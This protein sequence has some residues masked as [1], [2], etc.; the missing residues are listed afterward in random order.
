MWRVQVFSA[1][2]F[3]ALGVTGVL[4]AQTEEFP[5]TPFLRVETGM[6]TAM[7]NRL[8]VDINERFLVT[9]SD[10]K[11]AR[12]WDLRNGNLLKILRPPQGGGNIGRLYAAAMSP[13]GVTVAVGGYTRAS[14]SSIYL[15]DRASG[16]LARHIDGLPSSVN[17]LSYSPDGRFLAAALGSNGMRVY[18]TSD[19]HEI[20]S[21]IQYNDSSYSVDFDRTGRLVATSF[22][23]SL[24]LYNSM[25]RL[26]HK[27][28]APGGKQPF[29]A[30]FSPDGNYIAVGFNDSTAVNVLSGENLSFLYAP[31]TSKVT[32]SVST[33]A[34]SRDGRLLYAA[35]GYGFPLTVVVRWT[36]GGRGQVSEWPTSPSSVMDLIS[37]S[38]GQIAFASADPAL[39]VLD[40]RGRTL[41]QRTQESFDLTRIPDHHLRLSRQGDHVVFGFWLRSATSTNQRN[42]RFS[43]S[44]RTFQLNPAEDAS[45]HSPRTDGLS[46]A[47]WKDTKRP[48]LDGRALPL[49]PYDM[50]RALAISTKADSFLLGS[51]FTLRLFDRQGQQRWRTDIPGVAWDVNLTPDGRYAVA[52]LGDGTLRW[53][54]TATGKEVLAFFVH[55]DGER[56][57][58]WTPEGFFDASPGGEALVGYHLNQGMDRAGE[59]VNVDQVFNL[60]YRPDLVGQRLQPGAAETILAA[61]EKIGDIR[62]VLAGGLPPDLERLSPAESQ[63][64]GEFDLKFR[65]KN[66]GGGIGRVVYR[67]DGVEQAGREVGIPLPGSDTVNRRFNLTPGRHEV[68][69]TVY[70]ARNQVESRSVSAVVN[71]TAQAQPPSLF[72]VAAGISQYR[73]SALNE[74]VKYASAD[75]K[76]VVER[77]QEQGKGLFGKVTPYPLYDH[78]ATRAGIEQAIAKVSSEIRSHDVFVLYLAGHGAAFDG[79][80]HFI[81]WEARYTSNDA[82]RQQSFDQEAFRLALSRI[83]A[84]KTLVLLDT[85]S[86][87]SYSEGRALSD[88]ASIDKFARITGRAT[89][90]AATQT[91]LEGV[92]NHGVFTYA[93]LEALSKVADADGLVGVTQLADYVVDLIPRITAERFKQEQIPMWIFQG[94]TFPIAR[95]R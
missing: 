76:A 50:S 23:G 95:K 69:A 2:T 59:F 56:W 34:W 45:L 22:D 29:R 19:Y 66:R 90:A 71:V 11:T 61:R 30:R 74:G 77:L 21:D 6:H 67:V 84:K 65:L 89:L 75:A 49:D 91:A 44:E 41:W 7:V 62:V 16:S 54:D 82:L 73:E 20:A 26:L 78:E 68:T 37:L 42:A 1:V 9:A 32:D 64:T 27:R 94:Q 28:Q 93:L 39:G 88:K 55:R 13:D 53:Y 18:R 70:N 8:S 33:V 81:P 80:Y 52:A 4:F 36:D 85:C 35:G 47:G 31:S 14:N 24:R 57:V 92:G 10:D 51:D 87:A 72:V 63:S 86:S 40:A 12:I 60:F 25:F 3:I 79:Q 17:H 46:V 48:T 43:L 15:F 5:S 83:P 38:E 58:A